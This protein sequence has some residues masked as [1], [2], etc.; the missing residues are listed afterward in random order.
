MTRRLKLFYSKMVTV[1][2]IVMHKILFMR[3]GN[4]VS[5]IIQRWKDW[6]YCHLTEG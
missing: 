5:R 4:I 6:R 2:N 3:T 1:F